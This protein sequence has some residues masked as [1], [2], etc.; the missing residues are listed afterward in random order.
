MFQAPRIHFRGK[1]HAMDPYET[2]CVNR[3]GAAP[4]R[5]MVGSCQKKLYF[6]A[7]PVPLKNHLYNMFR[8]SVTTVIIPP[9]LPR[10]PSP[11]VRDVVGVVAPGGPEQPVD[12][13]HHIGRAKGPRPETGARGCV[14]LF[15]RGVNKVSRFK[16]D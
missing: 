4:L 9:P 6:P 1:V 8:A 13:F 16:P 7:A 10:T 11:V 2:V 5:S 12:P 15:F 3:I 14:M